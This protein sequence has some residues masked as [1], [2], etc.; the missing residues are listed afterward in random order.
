MKEILIVGTIEDDVRQLEGEL[1]DTYSFVEFE[2]IKEGFIH[3]LENTGRYSAILIDHPSKQNDD[4]VVVIDYLSENSLGED[5]VPVLIFT[6]EEY[7]END[8]TYLGGAVID[9]IERPFILSV[10]KN[11]I[12]RSFEWIN[13]ISFGGFARMLKALPANVYLKDRYGRYV[14]SAQTW[15]HLDTGDDP[16][17]SIVGKTD[18]DIRKDKENAKKALDSDLKLIETGVGSNYIIQEGTEDDPEYLQIIKEPL[19]EKNGKTV[20]GII[21]LINNVT[22]QELMRQKLHKLAVTDNLTGLYNKV[23]AVNMANEFEGREYSLK[24]GASFA[25]L[26]ADMNHFKPVNDTYGH[27]VGDVILKKMGERLKELPDDYIVIRIGG[28]EFLIV[29]KNAGDRDEIIEKAKVVRD[30]FK[31]PVSYEELRFEL[32]ASI[33]ISRFP[34]DGTDTRYLVRCADAAMYDVKRSEN[35]EDIRFFEPYMMEMMEN[36]KQ[37]LD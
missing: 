37:E 36:V 26:Y 3:L 33:G 30:I 23:Y 28:D 34:D 8:V 22:E 24:E 13:S 17:W 35:R 10:V 4:V 32:S 2:Q 1:S 12:N 27:E 18:L 19:F 20:K 21:A 25:I 31:E 7:A 11:R 15:H 29:L 9:C 14:F 5:A 16:N 6:D